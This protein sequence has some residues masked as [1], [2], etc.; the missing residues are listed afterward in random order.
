MHSFIQSTINQSMY[1]GII[2]VVHVVN[3][4]PPWPPPPAKG[5]SPSFLLA[6]FAL[7]ITG[8]ATGLLASSLFF[9]PR[10]LFKRSLHF[11]R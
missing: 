8:C 6:H 10:A 9:L 7:I 1:S 5:E 11:G 2:S 3:P 4:I